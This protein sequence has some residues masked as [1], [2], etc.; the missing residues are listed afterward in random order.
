MPEAL[1]EI[2]RREE[3][4]A[5]HRLH[6]SAFSADENLRL[7]GPCNTLHGHN[8]GLEVSVLGPLDA[9]TGMVM[10]LS[11]LMR[12]LR[13]TII[14]RLDH[15]YLNEDVPFLKGVIPTAENLAV[16][17]WD[18]LEPLM[19]QYPSCRLHRIRLHES[20][21]NIAEYL[22]PGSSPRRSSSASS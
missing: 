19:R 6:S 22:G 11:D 18:E 12:L 4:S 13:E 1:V 9:R 16:A 5:A 10:N 3:F 7:Y 21:S 2:T 15:K 17:I 8:Y 20:A 14:A